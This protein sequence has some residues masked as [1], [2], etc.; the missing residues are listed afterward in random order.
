MVLTSVTK[1][2]SIFSTP[3]DRLRAEVLDFVYDEHSDCMSGCHLAHLGQKRFDPMPFLDVLGL[4]I[5][6]QNAGPRP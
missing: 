4:V 5:R 3:P 6:V 2:L 1:K